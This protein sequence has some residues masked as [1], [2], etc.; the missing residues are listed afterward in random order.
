MNAT[1]VFKWAL[2]I[3]SKNGTAKI[4]KMPAGFNAIAKPANIPAHKKD[5]R[6]FDITAK[7][8]EARCAVKQIK[9]T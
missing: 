9:K 3:T 2:K 7:M 1:T 4:R 8:N 6:L 5:I